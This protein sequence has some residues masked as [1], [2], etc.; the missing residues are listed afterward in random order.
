LHSSIPS[1]ILPN[2]AIAGL[3]EHGGGN[4]SIA[5]RYLPIELTGI[6][7]LIWNPGL[8]CSFGSN[9]DAKLF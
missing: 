5:I 4:E 8:Y 3:Q 7:G 1:V 2:A 6:G 9:G